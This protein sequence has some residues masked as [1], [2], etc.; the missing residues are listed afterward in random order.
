MLKINYLKLPQVA[1]I[2]AFIALITFSP[3]IHFIPYIHFHDCQRILQLLLLALV[4][5][6]GILVGIFNTN[7]IRI[8]KNIKYAFF[9]LLALACLS[10]F[11][12]VNLRQAII[13]TSIFTALCYLALFISR[14]YYEYKDIFIKRLIYALWISILLYMVSFY[15]GYTTAIVFNKTL[16]WP[17]PFFGFSNIRLFQQYQLWSLG[18]ICLPLL[19]NDIKHNIR[20]WLYV[21][22]ALWWVLLFY[23]ASRGVDLSWIIAVLATLMIFGRLAWPLLRLQLITSLSG[24]LSYFLLFKVIPRLLSSNTETQGSIITSTIFRSTTDDRIALWKAAFNMIKESP[25]LGVGPMNFYWHTS[26]GTHPHNSVLQLAA[27][28][29]LPATFI[30]LGITSYGLYCWFKKFKPKEI[31]NASNTEINL[32]VILFF[33]IFANGAYSL[34]EG[35]I[36]MPISQTLMFTV[37]G[38]MLGQYFNKSKLI[39]DDGYPNKKLRF[40]PIFAVIVLIAMTWST[41]PEMQRGLTVQNRALQPGEAIFSMTPNTVNPRIWMQQRKK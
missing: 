11:S 20:R 23:A 19:T 40:R 1:S 21:A 10:S 22:L 8:D 35:V 30:I 4:L 2:L 36:V 18:L 27:E 32:T 25:V 15:V 6:D 17:Y 5:I 14:L 33:T 13:E 24:L 9:S 38:L 31:K 39:I 28:F 7:T 16:H 29:G 34:V 41:L 3:S 12:A 26:A 37:I